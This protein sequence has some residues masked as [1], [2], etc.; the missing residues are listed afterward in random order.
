MVF[1]SDS[2]ALVNFGDHSEYLPFVSITLDVIIY[3]QAQLGQ[4]THSGWRHDP[5]PAKLDRAGGGA[6]STVAL[7]RYCSTKKIAFLLD[8][9]HVTRHPVG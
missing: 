9:G 1:L 3:A 7:C 8:A 2:M 5:A 6:R 4:T